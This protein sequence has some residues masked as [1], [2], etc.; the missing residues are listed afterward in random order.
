M[1]IPPGLCPGGVVFRVYVDGEMRL[2]RRVDKPEDAASFGD[3]DAARF[4]DGTYETLVVATY[5][6]DDGWLMAFDEHGHAI[7]WMR[8][9][10]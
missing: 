6:G 10:T 7:E 8:G 3:A 4:P 5:D 1:S 2:E 9:E